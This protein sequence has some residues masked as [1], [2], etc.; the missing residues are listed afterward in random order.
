M[1]GRRLLGRRFIGSSHLGWAVGPMGQQGL[2]LI[3]KG[4]AGWA[5]EA[6]GAA[7][8]GNAS[9]AVE[10]APRKRACL[11]TPFDLLLLERPAFGFVSRFF[12]ARTLNTTSPDSA[13]M[14]LAAWVWLETGVPLISSTMSPFNKWS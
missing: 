4:Q 7:G 13:L 6:Q 3:G 5:R 12:S 11:S 9:G 1:V 14:I 2:E 8:R 10:L